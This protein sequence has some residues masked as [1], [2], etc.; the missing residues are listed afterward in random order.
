MIHIFVFIIPH[1]HTVSAREP[2]SV[3]EGRGRRR[4]H[5]L[6]GRRQ[7]GLAQGLT[8][9]NLA[10]VKVTRLPFRLWYPHHDGKNAVELSDF[11]FCHGRH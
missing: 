3:G 2:M 7:V 11:P 8:P 9:W 5:G 10:V 6:S 1:K 4:L